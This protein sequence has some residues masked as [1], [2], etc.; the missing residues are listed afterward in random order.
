LIATQT[1]TLSATNWNWTNR[2][3]GLL[4]FLNLAIAGDNALVWSATIQKG[5]GSQIPLAG[6]AY[7]TSTNY[8]TVPVKGISAITQDPDTYTTFSNG[9]SIT[10]RFFAYYPGLGTA[11]TVQVAPTLLSAIFS[12]LDV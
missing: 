10:I 2:P 9:D 1:I 12:A 4:G 6:M 5:A 7:F 3:F 8:I 11:P